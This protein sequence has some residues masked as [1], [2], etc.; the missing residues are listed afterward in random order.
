[1]KFLS[2]WQTFH[3]RV[4]AVPVGRV[5]VFI[6]KYVGPSMQYVGERDWSLCT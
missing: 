5:S 2:F 1:M 3:V 4:A 6:Q